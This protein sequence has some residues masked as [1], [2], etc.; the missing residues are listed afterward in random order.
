MQQDY[1]YI[2]LGVLIV[3]FWK[4]IKKYWLGIVVL[5][6]LGAAALWGYKQYTYM[7]IYRASSSFTV[8]TTGVG[9]DN[10]VNTTYGFYYD[11]NTADQIEKT[12]PYILGSSIL[13]KRLREE[14]NAS[15]V[16]GSISAQV[17]EDSNLATLTVTSYNKESALEILEAVIIVYPEIA[18]YVIGEIEFEFISLPELQNTPINVPHQQKDI[19]MGAA[20]GA[21]FGLMLILFYALARR[22][23]RTEKDLKKALSTTCLGLVPEVK[24][25]KILITEEWKQKS[26]YQEDLYSLQNRIDYLLK[27]DNRKVLLITSTEAGEGKTTLSI[28]L[29]LAMAQR[30]KKVLLID[31]DLR[32]PNVNKRLKFN[33]T[34]PTLANVFEGSATLEEATQYL[35]DEGLYVLGCSNPMPNA[36]TLINSKHMVKIIEEARRFAEIVILD[37]PPCGILA[38]AGY[39]YDYVD[40]VLLVLRQDWVKAS[41]VMDAVQGLPGQGEKLIGCVMNMVK[42]GFTSYGYGYSSYGYGYSYDKYTHYKRK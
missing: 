11:K 25:K 12:F 22:T 40:G 21:G 17:I 23:I 16:N 2:D 39:Y 38:D 3:D 41:S 1:E 6:L 14:L 27:K 20:A 9:L 36:L 29:A 31:G 32:K 18:E 24:E 15:Y 33:Y 26:R 8:K 7:P 4:G 10:E 37:S 5:A 28:N 13:Q 42:T 19:V 34:S 30:G 35:E